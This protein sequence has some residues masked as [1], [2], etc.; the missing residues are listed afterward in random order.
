MPS[1]SKKQAKTMRAAAHNPG[2]AKRMGIPQ[3]V[4]KDFESADR[5]IA[6]KRRKRKAAP[7]S[8]GY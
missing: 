8:G 2:Y 1:K 6:K 7:A 3:G 4:A 5:S